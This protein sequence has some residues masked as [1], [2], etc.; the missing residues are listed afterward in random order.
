MKQEDGTH[1]KTIIVTVAMHKDYELPD[2]DIYLPIHV[3]AELHPDI[4]SNLQQDNDGNNIYSLNPY[5]SALIAPYWRWKNNDSNCK[6]LVHYWRYFA[7][8]NPLK[9]LSRNRF[10]RIF[11]RP[12]FEKTLGKH[13]VLLTAERHY[14]IETVAS[15]YERALHSN[16]P[17]ITGKVLC[18]LVPSY[19]ESWE[20]LFR[21]RSANIFTMMVMD[22]KTFDAYCA[23]LFLIL[24]ELTKRLAPTQY[25]PFHARYPGRIS[26]LLL[27]VWL[28]SNGIRSGELP[29]T[30]TEPI[31]WR[32]KGTGFLKVKFT[33]EKY[34]H[35][36]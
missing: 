2:V 12:K 14:V 23:W 15:H 4:P 35:N 36:F 10:D 5:F 1:H 16:Q 13:N 22:R 26:E 25:T 8:S 24:F 9:W 3:G 30:F 6:D 19:L 11:T 34:T 7:T 31:N 28:G 17:T 27:N 32:A 29:T 21:K 18:D 33:G 20:R